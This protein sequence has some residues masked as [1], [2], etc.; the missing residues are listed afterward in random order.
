MYAHAR[1]LHSEKSAV[2]YHLVPES[3]KEAQS[4]QIFAICNMLEMPHF[5]TLRLHLFTSFLSMPHGNIPMSQVVTLTNVSL[6]PHWR[7]PEWPHKTAPGPWIKWSDIST[8][9][10]LKTNSD[11]K[12]FD[13]WEEE[14]NKSVVYNTFLSSLVLVTFIFWFSIPPASNLKLWHTITSK[15]DF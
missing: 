5:R 14:S 3:F 11:C 1:K 15:G 6:P 9:L 10:S 7:D 2:N 4:M 12:T 13:L 8:G